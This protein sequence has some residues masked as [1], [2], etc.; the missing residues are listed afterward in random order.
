MIIGI[1]SM[2]RVENYGSYLQAYALKRIIENLGNNKVKFVDYKVEACVSDD[3]K[4]IKRS[5]LLKRALKMVSPK[6]RAWR[7]S[8]LRIGSTFGDFCYTYKHMWLPKLGVTE[9]RTEQTQVDLLIIGSD[10]V[11]NCT[12]SEQ[13]VGF[14]RQLFGADNR[15][16]RLISYA[17]SFGSTTFMRLN[18]LSLQEDVKLLL[19]NFQSISVRDKNSEDIVK[20]LINIAPYRHL[21]PVLIYPFP[22]VDAIDVNMDNYMIVY[23]YAD[24]LLND[25]VIAIRKFAQKKSLRILT[26]GFW[27]PYSDDYVLASPIEVL[28]YIKKARFIVTDTFHGTVFSIKYSV[29]FSVFVRD[30]NKNKVQDLLEN[31]NL[32]DRIASTPDDLDSILEQPLPLSIPNTLTRE[33]NKTQNYLRK[34]LSLSE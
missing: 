23:A 19:E 33:M 9:R 3:E 8:Q 24:R 25:E 1:M 14:S 5:S 32:C 22:E 18:E 29:P 4:I 17:A 7:D 21:D 28:A 11:F 20:S 2:Q 10:E 26:L 16:K 13:K 30:S 12:Q 15:A 34:E 6:Y 27:Q 31:F